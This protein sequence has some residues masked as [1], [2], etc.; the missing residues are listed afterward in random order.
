ML[1][2]S[3][4]YGD[5]VIGYSEQVTPREYDLAWAGGAF[6]FFGCSEIE[7]KEKIIGHP[8]RNRDGTLKYGL[9]SA[10]KLYETRSADISRDSPCWRLFLENFAIHAPEYM[11]PSET[12]K[13]AR[14]VMLDGTCFTDFD[15]NAMDAVMTGGNVVYPM[16]PSIRLGGL[17]HTPIRMIKVGSY[18]SMK[19]QLKRWKYLEINA[20][21]S[22]R[23]L[24]GRGMEPFWQLDGNHCKVLQFCDDRGVDYDKYYRGID[25]GDSAV[26]WIQTARLRPMTRTEPIPNSYNPARNV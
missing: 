12:E 18:E 16:G 3:G 25:R 17:E 7:Q 24:G 15:G 1:N 5:K 8:I 20:T 13:R 26:N 10:I 2:I 6:D 21:I 22:N 9:P 23:G 11:S 14:G 19:S 4:V